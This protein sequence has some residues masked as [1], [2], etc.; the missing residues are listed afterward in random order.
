[1]DTRPYDY[2]KRCLDIVIAL[3]LIPSAILLIAFAAVFVRFESP[4]PALFSQVRV[5][6]NQAPFVMYKIRTMYLNTEVRASHEVGAAQITNV[7][8]TLRRIKFDEL[9]QLWSV[10]K[11]DMSFVGPRPGLPVQHEL[12]R[13]RECRGVFAVRPGITGLAQLSGVDM[14]TPRDLAVLDAAYIST[15]SLKTDLQILLSTA[16]GVG[17][18]DAAGKAQ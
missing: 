10:L 2:V 7:G 17:R 16:F 1:M 11:G 8:R 5:G 3:L 15:R 18:G 6:R 9:P 4:G 13:E 12:T 14:S